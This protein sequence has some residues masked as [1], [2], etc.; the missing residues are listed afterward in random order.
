MPGSPKVRLVPEV[1]K[2]GAVLAAM[3]TL[4]ADGV[5]VEVAA[6]LEAAGIV[7]I[8]LKG[9]VIARWLYSD[10][11]PRFYSDTDLLVSP[12]D[13][14]RAEGVLSTLGFVAD[15][16]TGRPDT[17][18]ARNHVWSRG[19]TIVE[20]HVSLVGIEVDPA[21]AWACLSENTDTIRLQRRSVRALGL[22]ARLLHIALH[23]AQH[24]SSFPKALQDLTRACHAHGI[25]DW[26]AAAVLARRLGAVD[27]LSAGLDLVADGHNVKRR[28]ALPTPKDSLVL[29]RAES[30]PP[31][32]LGI[33]RLVR[34]RPPDR[35]R[36]LLRLAFPAP[37]FLRWWTP[38]ARRGALGLALAYLWRYS[39]LIGML[40]IAVRSY[41]RARSGHACDTHAADPHE[42]ADGPRP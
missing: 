42:R 27:A 20:I 17:G 8:L 24:G 2:A 9:P 28:L 33:A 34:E 16:G 15:A 3:H 19:G 30:A 14:A 38:L 31:V 36:H 7:P 32:A 21:A 4:A 35:V 41:L 22:P 11:S 6:A 12:H 29:L 23:A 37:A 40:P 13:E 25:T 5:T 1:P 39:Y 10:D 18:V 26:R